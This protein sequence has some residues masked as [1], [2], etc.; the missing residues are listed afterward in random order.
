[1][2]NAISDIKPANNS[3]FPSFL[4]II[5]L[6]LCIINCAKAVIFTEDKKPEIQYIS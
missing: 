2:I 1:M 4:T 5:W 3:L 6:P